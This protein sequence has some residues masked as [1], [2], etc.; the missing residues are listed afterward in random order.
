MPALL[1]AGCGV[2]DAAAVSRVQRELRHEVQGIVDDAQA[3]T[4]DLV[5]PTAAQ[6]AGAVE[7]RIPPE[8]GGRRFAPPA[9][10]A[11]TAAEAFAVDGKVDGY[12]PGNE[13]HVVRMCV[14]VTLT[15]TPRSAHV[16]DTACPGPVG[17]STFVVPFAS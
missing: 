13:T 7:Q 4:A 15:V 17:G 16:A 1:L 8:P 5:A 12:G 9:S 14:V 2:Q 11:G 3:Q 10:A 6:L